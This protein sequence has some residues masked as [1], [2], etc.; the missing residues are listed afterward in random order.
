MLTQTMLSVIG[1]VNEL[2]RQFYFVSILSWD[3]Q[4]KLF[5]VAKGYR[6]INLNVVMYLSRLHPIFMT[7]YL[8]YK[9]KQEG[10]WTGLGFLTF[11]IALAEVMM[12]TFVL[13]LYHRIQSFLKEGVYFVNQVFQYSQY[14]TCKILNKTNNKTS[15]SK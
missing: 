8:I 9:F 5:S 14:I 7:T 3:K 12:I 11:V 1:T 6:E 15:H 13:L 2:I 4:S 10:T